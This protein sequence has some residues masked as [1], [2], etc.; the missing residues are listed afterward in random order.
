VVATK[1]DLYIEH[2]EP[3]ISRFKETENSDEIYHFLVENSNLPGR[4][5]NLELASAFVTI[6]S[7]ETETNLFFNLCKSFLEFDPDQAPTNDPKE[8]IPF[9]GIWIIGCIGSNDQFFEE[10]K[11]IIYQVAHDSRW[12]MREAVAKAITCLIQQ[13]LEFLDNI[14]L[15]IKNNDWLLFRAIAAGIADPTLLSD[16]KIAQIA[17][18]LHRLIFTQI[19][20]INDFE[21]FSCEEFKILQKGLNYTLSVVVAEIP[22]EGFQFMRDLLGSQSSNQKPV[23]KIIRENLKKNRLVKNFPVEIAE[24]VN[25]NQ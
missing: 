2:L 20:N 6:V 21:V 18:E 14:K 11:V 19:I 22:Q 13:N 5:A 16:L 3:I 9:C 12:R 17:L 23:C 24:L 15:W 10:T 1:R 7:N 8:F 25:L 4:R